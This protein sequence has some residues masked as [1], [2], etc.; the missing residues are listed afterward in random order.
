LHIHLFWGRQG[1]QVTEKSTH[2]GSGIQ[3]KEVGE[4]ED[5]LLTYLQKGFWAWASVNGGAFCWFLRPEYL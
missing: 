2:T 4:E 5:L 3:K 1:I